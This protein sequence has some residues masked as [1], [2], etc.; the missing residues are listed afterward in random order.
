[1]P[2]WASADVTYFATGDT[3]SLLGQ[4]GYLD[5]QFE[6]GPVGTNPENAIVTQFTT[7]GALSGPA[8]LTGDVTGQLPR[9]AQF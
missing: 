1:V 9:N 8:S 6:P 2:Q 4:N 3:S 7:N 5:L